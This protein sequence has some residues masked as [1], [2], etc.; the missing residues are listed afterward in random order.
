MASKLL[1]KT[2]G[3]IAGHHERNGCFKTIE[4]IVDFSKILTAAVA[5]NEVVE[6]IPIEAN[7]LVL[8]VRAEVLVVEGA[9]RNFAIGDGAG[10]SGYLTTQSANALAEFHSAFAGTLGGTGAAGDPV[11]VTGYSAG[12]YYPTADTIDILAVTAG[13]LTTCKIRLSVDVIEYTA[14]PA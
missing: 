2:V 12:K 9:A 5:Q 13:G 6:A 14:V 1:S 3:D 7:T 8:G 4:A 11:V 10:T